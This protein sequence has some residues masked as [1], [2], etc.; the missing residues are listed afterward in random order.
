MLIGIRSRGVSGRLPGAFDEGACSGSTERVAAEDPWTVGKRV[1]SV[2]LAAFGCDPECLGTDVDE[3]RRF[4]EVE[5]G[6]DAICGRLINGDIVMRSQRRHALAGP[7][8]AV[9]GHEFVPVEDTGN[10]IIVGDEHEMSD[11]RDDVGRGAVALSLSPTRQAKLGMDATHPVDHE[12]DL[13]GLDVDIRDHLADQGADNAFLE[14]RISRRSRP[15]VAEITCQSG[16][17]E[18]CCLRSRRRGSVIAGDL[19]FDFGD[20]GEC[21]VPAQLQFIGDQ[22]VGRIGGVVLAEGAIRRIARRFEI[23]SER[24][25]DCLLYTSPSPR[26]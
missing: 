3:R 17:G 14:P 16:E 7:A 9:A 19:R 5:P 13:G 24:F 11:R 21:L 23:A 22:T 26:D 2:D 10:E 4:G 18:R 6:F 25:A 15:D 20:A 12:H 8:V 1:V